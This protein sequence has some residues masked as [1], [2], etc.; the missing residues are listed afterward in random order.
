LYQHQWWYGSENKNDKMSPVS[1]DAI[2][3]A[4]VLC[5]VCMAYVHMRQ[6]NVDF[7]IVWA[8]VVD[9]LGRASV[10]LL[11][12]ISGY[13]MVPFFSRRTWGKLRWPGREH[14]SFPW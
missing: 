11:S 1:S 2:R 3:I 10:P 7:P 13:L 6:P 12:V 14:S 8:V 4:R 9:T 5:I